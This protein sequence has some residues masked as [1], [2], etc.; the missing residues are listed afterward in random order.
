MHKRWLDPEGA[1]YSHTD[2]N[3]IHWM[4]KHYL[5]SAKILGWLPS[6][7][8]SNFLTINL[9]HDCLIVDIEKWT[10]T[11]MEIWNKNST[12]NVESAFSDQPTEFKFLLYLNRQQGTIR[13]IPSWA[14]LNLDCHLKHEI[15]LLSKTHYGDFIVLFNLLQN[16]VWLLDFFRQWI[17]QNTSSLIL[18]QMTWLIL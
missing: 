1:G 16:P 5:P 13:K 4:V 6:Y 11:H 7:K 17:L 18:N 15:T 14:F 8:C 3:M 10:Y 2:H 9:I 12:K